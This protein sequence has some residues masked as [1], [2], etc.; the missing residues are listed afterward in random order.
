MKKTLPTIIVYTLMIFAICMASTFCYR[1]I[2][3]L[4]PG[5]ANSYR[6]IRG[7][8]FFLDLLPAILL[9]GF[10]VACSIAWKGEKVGSTKR[11]SEGMFKRF[12]GVVLFALILTFILTMT[13]EVLNPGVEKKYRALMNGPKELVSAK[14]SAIDLLSSENPELA[15]PYALRASRICP[16]D[17]ESVDLL[18]KAKNALD[19]AYDRSVYGEDKKNPVRVNENMPIHAE[20]QS[21]TA[22]QMLEKS[23]EAAE[24]NDWYLAHYWASL[25][26][27]ASD[28]VDT[29][30]QD[31]K[32][33]A[34][35]AWGQL[36]NPSGFGNEEDY[37]FY[38]KKMQAYNALQAGNPSDNLK[39]YYILKSLK[40][41][42]HDGEPDI[43]RFLALAE[44]SVSNE[45]FFI[46]EAENI[47][48]LK[49]SGDIYF[50]LADS[51]SGTKNVYYIKGAM[52]SFEDGR[53]VRYLEGLTIAT[54][55]K[56]GKFIR[57]MYAP[58]AKVVS[59]SVDTFDDETISYK[60]LSKSWKN[61]P[62]VMLLAVDRETDGVVTEPKYSYGITNLPKEILDAEGMSASQTYEKPFENDAGIDMSDPYGTLR[63]EVTR[64]LPETRTMVLSM[65]YE[66]FIAVNEAANGPE[67]M[68]IITLSSFVKKAT[69][70]GYSREV[71]Y[72]DLLGRLLY[73]LFLLSIMILCATCGWNYR[74][75]GGSKVQFRFR[76]IFLV[77][78]TGLLAFILWETL[79]YIYNMLNYVICGS[80]GQA[81]FPVTLGIYIGLLILMSVLFLSRHDKK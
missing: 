38:Q 58:V 27:K 16:K 65:P 13:F 15:Y 74:I 57:S 51:A 49:N 1:P 25:A 59:Q 46:D 43:E 55:S 10:A 45:Y 29:I 34:A 70:Y 2:P 20:D 50:A 68:D 42:G 35:S 12:G 7:V 32:V 52:D 66:D 8:K 64:R 80:C 76:W 21:Y 81:T 33:A 56:S 17:E 9:S 30:M 40:E 78:I 31:A 11:F 71:F 69:A 36:K 47:E 75:E 23:N 41:N 48:K 18:K 37:A 63:A 4:N 19:L 39:A 79:S 44:E 77:P 62:F 14:N 5:D 61:V 72:K 53:A 3:E 28:G 67:G 22:T 73:P 60:G 6:F 24:K 54:F 26:V